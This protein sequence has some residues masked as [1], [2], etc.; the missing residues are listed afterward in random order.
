MWARRVES[1]ARPITLKNLLTHTAGF[2]YPMWSPDVGRYAEA[3][4]TPP[5]RSGQLA[6]LQMP[7]MFDPG[8]K[9][10]Y[11][12]NID[13]GGRL[14]EELGGQD[15]NAYCRDHICA[16]LRM[17]ETGYVLMAEQ[18][19]RQAVGHQRLTDAAS[20]CNRPSDRPRPS[21]LPAALDCYRPPAI[22]SAF[23]HAAE[24]RQPPRRPYPETGD[25]GVDG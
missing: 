6:A 3:T 18:Q 20:W 19:A 1:S 7:L 15:L 8:E 9:W 23:T 12:I 11:G 10:E 22:T 2:G 4:A 13:W 21:S 25:G 24:W 5:M 17:A 14:V 16:P